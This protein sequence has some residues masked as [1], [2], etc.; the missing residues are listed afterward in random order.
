MPSSQALAVELRANA[1]SPEQLE[2]SLVAECP[3]GRGYE[4]LQLEVLDN[5]GFLL[6]ANVP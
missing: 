6:R 5:F 4:S 3:L 1:S 2:I